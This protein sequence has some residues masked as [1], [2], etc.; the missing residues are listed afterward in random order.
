M[1]ISYKTIELKEIYVLFVC[2]SAQMEVW[3]TVNAVRETKWDTEE[4]RVGNKLK[5]SN[6]ERRRRKRREK[7]RQLTCTS[8]DL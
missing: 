2:S 3:K 1:Q 5:R 8:V 6:Q 7:E 4:K